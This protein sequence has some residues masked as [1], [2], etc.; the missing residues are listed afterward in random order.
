MCF[1]STQERCF[2]SLPQDKYNS[3]DYLLNNPSWDKQDS[4]WKASFVVG[5]LKSAGLQPYSICEVGCGAGGVL[6]Q[7]S[8]EY[9]DA[10][11]FGYDIASD[12][13]LFWQEHDGK[14]IRFTVG[15][16]FSLNTR[17]FDIILLLDVL[18]HVPDPFSFLSNLRGLA[19][20]YIFHFPLD[21]SALN[22]VR[23]KPILESR[24]KVGHIH[25][26]TKNLALSLLTE[27]N[28]EIVNWW[29]SGAAFNTPKR[30][31]KTILAS[32]PRR[33]AYA[34][35]KDLGVRALGGE[36]LFVLARDKET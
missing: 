31:W 15:D 27:C 16:F 14:N 12:A 23:E 18:E 25:Y 26:F 8:D 33:I 36:T 24:Q 22:I 9:S 30:T 28:F 1:D 10:E 4:P 29:Y 21:L 17:Q 11:L 3:G 35:N 7:L 19:Q 2:M 34:I 5:I 13:S 6:A 20:N 32:F